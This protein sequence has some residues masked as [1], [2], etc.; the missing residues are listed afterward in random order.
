M[1]DVMTSPVLQSDDAAERTLAT[2][3]PELC[4]QGAIVNLGA[5]TCS[6]SGLERLD[7]PRRAQNQLYDS[8]LDA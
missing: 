4:G 2:R 1:R 7:Q 3:H 6:G 5:F 8:D